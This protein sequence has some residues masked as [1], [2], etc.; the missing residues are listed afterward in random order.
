MVAR[1]SISLSIFNNV[2]LKQGVQGKRAFYSSARK[3]CSKCTHALDV[4]GYIRLDSIICL[5][6]VCDCLY[7]Y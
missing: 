1:N 5:Q 4:A 3:D 6:C 2:A 7:V